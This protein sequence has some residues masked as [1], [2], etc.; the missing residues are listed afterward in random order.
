MDNP[1]SPARSFA[2]DP[3][4]EK[5]IAWI[6]QGISVF[7]SAPTGAGKTVIAEVAIEEALSSGGMAIYTAPIKALSN[8]KFRDFYVR[9]GERVGIL[10]GDVT[11]NANA[12]LLIMTT[13]I[14]RNSLLEEKGRFSNCRWIIFDE[15]HF[16]DDLERG[17]VWEEALLLTPRSTEILALSATIPNAEQMAGW[18]EKIHGRPV[19]VI[20]EN[21]RPVPLKFLFQCQNELISDLGALKTRGYTGMEHRTARVN[22]PFRAMRRHRGGGKIYFRGSPGHG[23]GFEPH[24]KS[25]RADSLVKTIQS[26]GRL[27]CLYFTFGR[28]R[29][30]ELAWELAALNFADPKTKTDLLEQFDRFAKR[31]EVAHERSVWSMRELIATGVAYHHA[32]LL[33]TLKEVIEQLFSRRLI[34]LIITTE[35]FALGVNMPARSVVLDT[36][37][38]RSPRG[39]SGSFARSV[40]RVRE[41]SQMAGRAGRRG[42]DDAGYV[43]LRVNPWE[44]PYQDV[45]RLLQGTPEQVS[46]R[47]NLTYATVLNLYKSYSQDLSGFYEKTFHAHQSSKINQKEAIDLI[48][49]KLSLLERMGYVRLGGKLTRKGEF[50]VSI[51]GYELFLS[52]LFEAGILDELDLTDLGI[53]LLATVYEPPRRAVP[54]KLPHRLR[55]LAENAF[56]ILNRIHQEERR[57]RV[58]PLTKGPAFHLSIPMERWIGGAGFDKVVEAAD[59]DEGGLIRN[60]RMTIQL[61]RALAAAPAARKELKEKSIRLLQKINRDQV[62]AEAELRRSL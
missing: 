28:K 17:T 34:P 38:K 27:P 29:A 9:Y 49:R 12:Q 50:A 6:R 52:E 23:G 39:G 5:A 45:T 3:F 59:V 51:Y 41:L 35:T 40:I 37:T 7:V 31:F 62:D 1:G 20:Q 24:G 26:A 18:I 56:E 25:N 32:G 33:P 61:C 44:V 58:F 16:L 15:V 42:M 14:Y 57:L 60:L 11:I 36:L 4:Q 30:E 8:Q 53:L 54:L 47:F 10:T 43:Y 46:S 2:F 22:R 13:E 19:K 48:K 55:G 21:H